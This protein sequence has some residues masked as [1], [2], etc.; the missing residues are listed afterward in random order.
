[1]HNLTRR[2]TVRS[3]HNCGHGQTKIS[4]AAG[5]GSVTPLTRFWASFDGLVC[6]IDSAHDGL[7]SHC[8]VGVSNREQHHGTRSAAALLCPDAIAILRS[9]AWLSAQMPSRGGGSEFRRCN[10]ARHAEHLA[11]APFSWHMVR[12]DSLR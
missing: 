2:S 3:W 1:M 10:P 8:F 4:K 11:G 5:V 9:W 6:M 7:D 12:S